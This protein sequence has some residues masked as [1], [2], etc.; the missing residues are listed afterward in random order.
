MHKDLFGTAL[1]DYWEGNYTEDLVTWTSISDEDSLPLSYLFRGIE[2]MPTLEQTALQ[3]AYGTVLDVGCGAGSHA[4][5]LQDQGYRVKCIDHSPGAVKVAQ[6][7][8]VQHVE[9]KTLLQETECF[10]TILLLMN[11]TGIF[12]EYSK[13]GVYL[14]HLRKIMSP[15]GQVL[16]DSSDLSYMYTDKDSTYCPEDATDYFGDLDYF[17]SYKGREEIPFKWLYLD[18]K[19]LESV[20]AASGLHCEK[21]ADGPHFD[22][23]AR[24]TLFKG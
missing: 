13:L 5:W 19:S 9:L 15:G 23:L 20:C 14:D 7:R 21:I 17:L 2:E 10:D 4:L 22:Y 12:E 6:L 1:M 24:L 11:G 16:I 18:F 8:G 3:M